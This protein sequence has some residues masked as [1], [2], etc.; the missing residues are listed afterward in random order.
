MNTVVAM[1][2]GIKNNETGMFG[3]CDFKDDVRFPTKK[4]NKWKPNLSSLIDEIKRRK[5]GYYNDSTTT[6]NQMK[7]TAAMER[8]RTH[9][10]TIRCDI[11]WIETKM[12]EFLMQ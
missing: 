11:E 6:N 1:S 10:V 4:K 8:L 5:K 7:K 3:S 9:P 2:I 12:V